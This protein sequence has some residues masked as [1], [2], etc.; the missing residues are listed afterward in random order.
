LDAR[1]PEVDQVCIANGRFARCG[2][3]RSDE[4]A[5]ESD[6]DRSPFGQAAA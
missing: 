6:V 1:K 3:N 5:I 4:K 2:P